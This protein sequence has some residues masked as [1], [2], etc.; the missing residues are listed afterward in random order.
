MIDE[1]PDDWR[2]EVIMDY[3]DVRRLYSLLLYTE[4]MWPGAPA[5]PYEEQEFIKHMKTVMFSMMADY[6]Y[7]F[8]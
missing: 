5:R 2:A 3:E 6:S 1:S 8:G 7:R 4:Q